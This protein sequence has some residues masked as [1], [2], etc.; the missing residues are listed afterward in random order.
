VSSSK[1]R[2]PFGLLAE[3][4]RRAKRIIEPNTSKLELLRLSIFLTPILYKKNYEKIYTHMTLDERLVLFFL[5]NSLGRKAVV[6]EIGSFL[7][8]SA[9]YLASGLRGKGKVYCVDTWNNDAMDASPRDTYTEFINNIIGVA[10]SVVPLRGLSQN[11]ARAFDRRIDLLFIDGDHSYDACHADWHCWST[12][13][14]QDA[15][16]VFHDS[17]WAEGV[18]KVIH[19]EVSAKTRRELRMNNMYVG[20]L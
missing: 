11:V 18:Q 20:W 3:D 15:I 13:L 4:L 5:A 14:K 6:T 10:E 9:C 2:G 19:D 1:N 17:G 12:C 16:V 7:G 8:A